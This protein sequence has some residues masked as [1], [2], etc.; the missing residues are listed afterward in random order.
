L[1][2]CGMQNR[3]RGPY[4]AANNR[5][6]IHLWSAIYRPVCSCIVCLSGWL[7]GWL[8]GWLRNSTWTWTVPSIQRGLSDFPVATDDAGRQVKSQKAEEVL[9]EFDLAR[10]VGR[11]IALQRMRRAVVL[12]V[13]DIADFD[14]SLPRSAL[15]A[16][17]NDS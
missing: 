11:K 17:R 16:V 9:P 14:G 3:T 12:C 1:V 4:M 15:L 7:A 8:A 2:L 10:K 5:I 6:L 13:V